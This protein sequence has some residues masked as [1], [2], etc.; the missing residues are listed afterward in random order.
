MAFLW[1]R[2]RGPRARS[3]SQGP[4]LDG[5]PF[6]SAE[7]NRGRR[8]DGSVPRRKGRGASPGVSGLCGFL[9]RGLGCLSRALA[10][11]RFAGEGQGCLLCEAR[12][13]GRLGS[14]EP[15]AVDAR[16]GFGTYGEAAAAVFIHCSPLGPGCAAGLR[17]LL[18]RGLGSRTSASQATR[19]LGVTFWE[20]AVR[21]SRLWPPGPLG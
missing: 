1:P 10:S 2:R 18:G 20:W 21:P 17:P 3:F 12:A 9:M 19:V 8:S 13:P 15:G 14:A 16:T 7:G 4:S 5:R 11:G 6:R